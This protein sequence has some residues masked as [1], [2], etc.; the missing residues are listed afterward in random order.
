MNIYK[1]IC[2]TD[3][4]IVG[5]YPQV[6]FYS[7]EGQERPYDDVWRQRSDPSHKFEMSGIMAVKAKRTQVLSCKELSPGRGLLME[8][9]LIEL[10]KNYIPKSSVLHPFEVRDPDYELHKY[11]YLEVATTTEML[12]QI[13]YERS[14]FQKYRFRESHSEVAVSS[15]QDWK[16]KQE[17]E[18]EKGS[19]MTIIPKDLSLAQDFFNTQGVLKLPFNPN[20]YFIEPV[21]KI[22]EASKASGIIL[23]KASK[24]SIK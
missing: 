11:S 23:T 3:L 1:A 17:A 24:I 4:S 21:A 13:D 7:I 15:W 22:I 14:S 10:F 5:A 12:D 16:E 2:E 18:N 8:N 9:S 20:I 19:S 6:T